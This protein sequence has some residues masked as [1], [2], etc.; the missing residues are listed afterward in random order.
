MR[1]QNL[2]QV[3]LLCLVGATVK[4]VEWII[5]WLQESLHRRL[6]LVDEDEGNL[7][8]MERELLSD[9]QVKFYLLESPLQIEPLA[10]RIAWQGVLLPIEVAGS[11]EVFD[12]FK[13]SLQET[14]LA[15][16]LLL[17][18]GADL[19]LSQF[20]QRKERKPYPIRQGMKL[21]DTCRQIPAI[22]IG[23]GPTLQK[24]GHLL[25]DFQDKALLFAGGSALNGIPVEPHFAASI[26]KAAPYQQFKQIPF[27]ETPFCFQSRVSAQN[28][29]LIHG[30]ALWFPESHHT[31]LNWLDGA[32]EGFDGG[33]TVSNFLTRIALLMGCNPIIF[34]GMDLCYQ[35][36]AKYAHLPNTVQPSLMDVEAKVFTQPDWL[37][38]RKWTEQVALAYPDRQFIDAREGG[39]PFA[40]PIEKISLNHL[41]LPSR[42]NLKEKVHQIVQGLPFIE[43]D[44]FEAWEKSLRACEQSFDESEIVYEKLLLPLW[45]LWRAVFERSLDLEQDN[46]EQKLELHR[47]LFFQRV[48]KE[49]IHGI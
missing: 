29:S 35:G 2:A 44:R 43:G 10:R 24:N 45:Q 49:Y 28:F 12:R 32:E 41:A 40:S 5:P 47:H 27:W 11:G 31:F 19:G 18:D 3:T 16:A 13:A 34:V 1:P 4:E 42:G 9:P 17:S 30:E 39:L 22:I 36:E 6:C 26:D 48:L 38:A 46:K 37:M 15:A 14:H 8:A 25:A 7:R 21:K 23:A 20:R 33:W